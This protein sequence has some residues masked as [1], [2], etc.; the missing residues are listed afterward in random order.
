M[1]KYR[2]K[3]MTVEA[4]QYFK[5][6]PGIAGVGYPPSDVL[7]PEIDEDTG[8]VVF[9]YGAYV[10]NVYSQ[11]VWLE[12]GDWVIAEPGNDLQFH[13]CKPEIFA[14]QYELAVEE[15]EQ[16]LHTLEEDFAHFLTYS[17]L[18]AAEDRE[19]LKLA[20]A[21]GA[22]PQPKQVFDARLNKFWI[23]GKSLGG[24]NHWEFQGVFDDE[25]KALR[26]CPHGAPYFLAPAFLNE[27]LPQATL[28][29]K[30]LYW[31]ALSLRPRPTPESQTIK[32]WE[33]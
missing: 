8:E 14:E 21:A 31:P 6:G 9:V 26:A 24:S 27:V 29:W 30:G 22:D 19:N 5:D 18:G 33:R 12:E 7:H 28:A 16:P 10:A 3:F 23:V 17:G 2:K 25:Q 13:V 1:A 32:E 15:D 20:F 11:L 4:N